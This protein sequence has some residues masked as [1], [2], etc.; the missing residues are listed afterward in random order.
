MSRSDKVQRDPDRTRRSD[1]PV[2]TSVIA[3]V[4]VAP[5]G[6]PPA[7]TTL[8][9]RFADPLPDAGLTCSHGWFDVAVHVTVPVPVCVS[10]TTWLRLREKRRAV[11]HRPEPK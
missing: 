5:A 6:S 4:T 1:A 10:R 11:G 9:D 8:R 3:P 2:N 7:E